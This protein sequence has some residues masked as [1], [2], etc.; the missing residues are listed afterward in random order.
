MFNV[1]RIATALVVGVAVLGLIAAPSSSQ[2]S[3]PQD[4]N[5]IE[6]AGSSTVF[7]LA[8]SVVEEFSQEFPEAEVNVRS[9]GSGGGFDLFIPKETDINN[10]SRPI[11]A[12][13]IERA[14]EAGTKF[15]ES[16]VA[17][18][19]LTVA[20]D[21]ETNIWKEGN[22]PCMT[23]GELQLLWSAASE[24]IVTNWSD[25]GSRF[26]DEPITLSG[27]ATTSGTFDF[28]T[29][30]VTGKEDDSREDYFATEEDSQLVER[31][32][33]NPLELTYFG[34][35]FFVNNQ[36]A[37]QPVAIDPSRGTVDA[38]QSILDEYNAA[39]E[40]AGLSTVS[41]SADSCQGVAP[42][43]DS[44]G[45]FDYPITR[46]LFFYTNPVSAQRPMVQNYVNFFLDEQRIGSQEFVL[47]V[48]Y[49]TASETLREASRQC[50]ENRVTGT[51]F[52]GSLPGSGKEIREAYTS[53]CSQ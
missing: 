19:G 53:H 44:I 25:L 3:L 10:A 42:S 37:V 29:E 45:A 47:D 13:E 39:R 51:A 34:F 5:K 30:K 21:Q 1:R 23:F 48:G 26:A 17:F 32:S 35:A 11:K 52:G 40:E 43:T 50:W 24:G 7:P 9:T 20:V 28:F 49:V 6:I 4:S 14:K 12:S 15:I 46:P 16:L 36:D 33:E 31:V 8:T 18:D 2:P 27:A 38:P 41:N 22:Q